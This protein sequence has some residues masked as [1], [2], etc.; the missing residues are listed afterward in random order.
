[1]ADESVNWRTPKSLEPGLLTRLIEASSAINAS[2]DLDEVLG[3]IV[4]LAM[5]MAACEG[6]SIILKDPV[7]KELVFRKSNNPMLASSGKRLVLQPGVG[8][9]GAVVQTG[10][11]IV[12]GNTAEDNRF[13]PGVDEQTGLKTQ[14]ILALPMKRGEEVIGVLEVINPLDQPTF[15]ETT[16]AVLMILANLSTTALANAQ[17]HE[18]V[19]REAE[20]LR[21]TSPHVSDRDFVGTGETARRLLALVRK[22]AQ[23]NA[24]VLISG[25]SGTGKEMVARL[26]HR[27]SDRADKPLIAVN[28]GALPEQLLES[29][30]FGHEKGAFTGAHA[31]RRGRF[32]LAHGGTL[33]LDEVGELAPSLQVKL[34][35]VLQERTFERVGGVE[36]IHVDVRI[37]AATNRR[38][39]EAVT[40]GEFREDLY[41][42]L[43]VIPIDVPPLRERREDIAPL[44][45]HFLARCI[46]N[47]GRH[48]DGF[49]P[50][51]L[52]AL[53]DAPWRGNIRELENCIERAAVLTDGPH[54]SLA[55]LPSDLHPS[56][57]EEIPSGPGLAPG[58]SLYDYEQRMMVEALEKCGWNVSKAARQLKIPRHHLRYRMQKYGIRKPG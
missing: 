18:M 11:P 44:A 36:T 39:R 2:L 56:H 23:S 7:T 8:I 53:V 55:D 6:C 3:R 45:E 16:T 9:C 22:A 5:E 13:F 20:G 37:I 30:L 14:A 57:R 27:W 40:S 31:R 49:T 34:L 54:V 19:A 25:E 29:E 26:L 28:C 42:R 15:T 12:V 48:L 43:N 35:R 51:A 52:Q 1:M 24:T 50:E 4:E 58:D 41:Y 38:I 21:R 33:F 46:R 47:L 10:E 32:E 17:T